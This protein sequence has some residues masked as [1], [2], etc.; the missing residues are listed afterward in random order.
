MINIS[1]V[2]Y[3]DERCGVGQVETVG[4]T[5]KIIPALAGVVETNKGRRTFVGAVFYDAQERR[6]AGMDDS[7]AYRFAVMCR[8][9]AG[10]TRWST[11]YEAP[12][13]QGT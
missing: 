12:Q 13:A 10:D 3:D 7:R 2:A 5:T 6:S 4:G 11:F 1:F 9:N 8:T